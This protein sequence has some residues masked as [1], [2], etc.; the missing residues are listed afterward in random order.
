MAAIG[1]FGQAGDDGGAGGHIDAGG[2]GFGG[3]DDF[4]Q[5]SLEELFD[6]AFPGG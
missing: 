5:S 3:E 6:E 4:N 1:A 2:E